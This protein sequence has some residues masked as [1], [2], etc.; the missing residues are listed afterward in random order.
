MDSV[1]HGGVM[2][3]EWIQCGAMYLEVIKCGFSKE[4]WMPQAV[5]SSGR[6]MRDQ[7]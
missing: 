4:Q 6:D 5:I 1:E 2:D 7:Q 3:S